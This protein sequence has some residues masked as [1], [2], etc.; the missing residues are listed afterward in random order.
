[1]RVCV[2]LL[3]RRVCRRLVIWCE[4]SF[5]RIFEDP[6]THLV[7]WAIEWPQITRSIIVFPA[8][9]NDHKP[10]HRRTLSRF[11]ATSSTRGDS[12]PIRSAFRVHVV[13][14]T[15]IDLE[16][17]PT[18]QDQTRSSKKV[19]YHNKSSAKQ[20]SPAPVSTWTPPRNL[21][22]QETD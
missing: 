6:S 17:D 11:N 2:C 21:S 16:E 4:S 9:G 5:M 8:L 19:R 7:K 15:I 14:E 12:K 20:G 3:R 10:S 18:L 13:Q 1:M 22:F